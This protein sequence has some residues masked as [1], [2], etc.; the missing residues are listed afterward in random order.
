MQRAFLLFAKIIL[1]PGGTRQ[2]SVQCKKRLLRA[3]APAQ[4]EG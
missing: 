3:F 1:P 4:E 2:A